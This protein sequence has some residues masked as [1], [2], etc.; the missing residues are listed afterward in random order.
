MRP[1]RVDSLGVEPRDHLGRVSK[2]PAAKR[3][4]YGV[5]HTSIHERVQL[6]VDASLGFG[7]VEARA[8]TEV[9]R[10]RTKL[11]EREDLIVVQPCVPE[12]WG[13]AILLPGRRTRL[14]ALT[15]H[16]RDAVQLVFGVALM[17][18]VAGV[19]EGHISPARIP[20][21][22]KLLFAAVAALAMVWY[23]ALAGRRP[24][25]TDA[26]RAARAPPPA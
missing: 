23:L 11:V 15:A 16:A 18:L 7:D 6:R 26:W 17:L 1:P 13:S 14:A 21:E 5:A 3:A 20:D 24:R 12:I 19:I 8:S 25:R 4:E 22:T 2:G 10:G 9:L